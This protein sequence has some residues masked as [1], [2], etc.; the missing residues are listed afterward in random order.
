LG[1]SDFRRRVDDGID[2]D[3]GKAPAVGAVHTLAYY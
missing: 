3:P 2:V 1:D